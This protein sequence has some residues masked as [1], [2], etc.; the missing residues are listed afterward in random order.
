VI[1]GNEAAQR[2]LRHATE[3]SSGSGSVSMKDA[4]RS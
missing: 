3:S 1:V 2:R 4:P